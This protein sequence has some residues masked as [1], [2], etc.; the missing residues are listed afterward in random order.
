M[1]RAMTRVRL[2]RQ[3]RSC[4]FRMDDLRRVEPSWSSKIDRLRAFV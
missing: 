3:A 1:A 2:E 4:V